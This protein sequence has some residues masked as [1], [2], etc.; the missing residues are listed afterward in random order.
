MRRLREIL[1]AR[2]LAAV[3]ARTPILCHRCVLQYAQ[4]H[5]PCY[6]PHCECKCSR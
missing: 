4:N 5:R 3:V 2:R 1:L 6:G